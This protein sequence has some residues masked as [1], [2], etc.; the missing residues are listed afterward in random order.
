MTKRPLF[1]AGVFP[2]NHA[3]EDL[4]RIAPTARTTEE[5]HR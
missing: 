4:Y 2:D 1:D 3:P 5:D